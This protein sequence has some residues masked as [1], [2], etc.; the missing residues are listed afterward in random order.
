[1]NKTTHDEKDVSDQNSVTELETAM[2]NGEQH[3]GKQ[4]ELTSTNFQVEMENQ[5]VEMLITYSMEQKIFKFKVNPGN[6]QELW[7]ANTGFHII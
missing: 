6:I 3:N 5:K 4:N 7:G 2:R 1:M